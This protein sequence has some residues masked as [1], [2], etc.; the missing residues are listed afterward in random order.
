[1]NDADKALD[2]SLINT[3]PAKYKKLI[4]FSILEF[5]SS[6]WDIFLV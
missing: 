5:K 6:Y 2:K 1:M 3:N 4:D